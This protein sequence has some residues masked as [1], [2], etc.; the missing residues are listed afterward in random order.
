MTDAKETPIAEPVTREN[1]ASRRLW[2]GLKYWQSEPVISKMTAIS[3]PTKRIT[4]DVPALRRIVRG[5]QS[6]TVYGLR[7]PGE[8][9]F[10]T[11]SQGLFEARD[12][13]FLGA[14]DGPVCILEF[15]IRDLTLTRPL[16]CSTR[17][18]SVCDIG[19]PQPGSHSSFQS[20]LDAQFS[21]ACGK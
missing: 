13:L 10:L 8:C 2:L 21:R 3:K 11:T 18:S 15:I 4:L 19:L 12:G 9:I 14:S 1:V 6:N 16:A 17:P 20:S 7:S 5:D